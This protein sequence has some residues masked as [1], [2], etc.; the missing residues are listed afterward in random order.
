[1][2]LKRLIGSVVVVLA[3]HGSV[4]EALKQTKLDM[5]MYDD[6]MF[7]QTASEP[8]KASDSPVCTL[9]VHALHPSPAVLTPVL[10]TINYDTIPGALRR[11]MARRYEERGEEVPF[12][13]LNEDE[14]EATLQS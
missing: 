8:E 10:P 9:K 13:L 7:A 12:N 2:L 11:R 1:M 6:V 5:G 3:Y 4:V 14:R